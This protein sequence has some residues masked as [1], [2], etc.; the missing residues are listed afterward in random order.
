MGIFDRFKKNETLK[1]K[2]DKAKVKQAKIKSEKKAKETPESK[3]DKNEVKIKAAT[4]P[5]SGLKKSQKIEDWRILIKPLISEKATILN[6][7][8]QYVFEVAPFATK[9]EIKK[10]I[11]S[12]YNVKPVK[13]NIINFSGKKVRYGKAH[14]KTKKWR[15]AIIMLKPEDKIEIYQGV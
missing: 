11:V 8:S 2:S 6:E 9:S 4:Q 14:G 13:I 1:V 5:Q 15:K 12:L 7:K 10:A 3:E